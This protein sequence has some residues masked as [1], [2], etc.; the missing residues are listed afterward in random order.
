MFANARYQF[1]MAYLMRDEAKV[2]ALAAVADALTDGALPVGTEAGL[3][4]VRYA[5]A[6]TALGH[7]ALEMG[8]TGKVLIDVIGSE[9]DGDE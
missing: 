7:E 1:V 4:L 8:A 2:D 3:P 9:G 6:D 5:L